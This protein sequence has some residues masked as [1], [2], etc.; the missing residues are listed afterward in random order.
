MM[1]TET[2]IFFYGILLFIIC[3]T[4]IAL[5]IAQ[6]VEGTWDNSIYS[7]VVFISW[8]FGFIGGVILINKTT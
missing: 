8:I 2:R 4:A 6:I 1:N 3:G 5:Q 7:Y